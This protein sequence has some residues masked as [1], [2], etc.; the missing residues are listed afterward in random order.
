MNEKLEYLLD[1]FR[2]RPERVRAAK[3]GGVVAVIAFVVLVAFLLTRGEPPPP[4]APKNKAPAAATSAP[5]VQDAFEFAQTLDAK[6]RSDA[7]Y[8]R[9]YLVPSAANATVKQGKIV[10]MGE[11]ASEADLLSLQRTIA[12]MGVPLLMEWQVVV[13]GGPEPPPEPAR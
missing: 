13:S 2:T 5:A 3:Y 6:L 1:D 9:I 12:E 11:I 8:A 4:P 7:R 10:V